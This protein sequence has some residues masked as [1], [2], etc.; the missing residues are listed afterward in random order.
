VHGMVVRVAMHLQGVW[1]VVVWVHILADILERRSICGEA[2][3]DLQGMVAYIVGGREG[4]E[5]ILARR[6]R[7]KVEGWR[8]GEEESRRSTTRFECGVERNFDGIKN[9]KETIQGGIVAEIA[10]SYDL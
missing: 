6:K 10:T 1:W 8:K 7:L 4:C 3:V 9:S 2:M 5:L